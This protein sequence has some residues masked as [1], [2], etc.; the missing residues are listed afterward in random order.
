M[1]CSG[2]LFTAQAPLYTVF[3]GGVVASREEDRKIVRHWF[4]M[5]GSG[6]RGVSSNTIIFKCLIY[7]NAIG[8]FLTL[9]E[10]APGL[11]RSEIPLGL[12]GRRYRG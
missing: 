3:I 9:V 6:T 4:E 5:V 7:Q 2:P 12:D 11:E 1:P 8:D 10:R